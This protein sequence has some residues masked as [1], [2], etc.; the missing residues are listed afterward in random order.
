MRESLISAIRDAIVVPSHVKEAA[1]A[2]AT[3]L[4]HGPQY[5]IRPKSGDWKDFTEEHWAPLASDLEGGPVL[6]VYSGPVGGMLRDFISELPSTMYADEDQ[7]HV[8]SEEPVGEDVDGEWIDAGAYCEIEHR[9]I[10]E[11]LF[12]STISREFR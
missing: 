5:C 6:S 1:T 4:M 10:I 8:S 3:D 9:E 7:E 12:G 11:A 2:C